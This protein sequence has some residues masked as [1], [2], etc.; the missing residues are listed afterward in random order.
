VSV[1]HNLI[2]YFILLATC[3]DPAGSSSGLHYE[4]FNVKKPRTSLGSQ[5]CLQKINIRGS[6][7]HKP[8]IFIFC[9]HCWDP[10]DVRSFLTLNGS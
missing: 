6:G 3:F 2:Y 5:Q 9:K 8:L 7:P 1:E 4:P 10:K